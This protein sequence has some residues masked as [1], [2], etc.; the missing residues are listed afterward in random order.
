MPLSPTEYN[1]Y[2]TAATVIPV[3]F[4]GLV[5]Q[6]G[7]WTW[8]EERIRTGG[9]ATLFVRIYVFSL[10]LG[11]LLVVAAGTIGEIIA[12][13]VLMTGKTGT[14]QKLIVFYST[15]ALTAMLGL[16]LLAKVPGVTWT[17]FA[18][19]AL[20]LDAG[21][22]L[23]YSPGVYVWTRR[24]SPWKA[25]KLFL[26]DKR[27]VWLTKRELGLSAAPRIEI[28]TTDLHSA[29]IAVESLF[30]KLL[31]LTVG[32]NIPGGYCLTIVTID[33]RSY[34]FSLGMKRL[35]RVKAYLEEYVSVG[36]PDGR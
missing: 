11:S 22:E 28:R 15:A 31:R 23:K 30:L 16:V 14:F 24:L 13:D 5:L 29:N 10:Q 17:R 27:V 21:E 36:E 7:F 6:G 33:H 20:V 4:L 8:I 18:D 9:D 32:S 12:L 2:I 19:L 26:T 35:E 34:K 25:G 1:F 3:I